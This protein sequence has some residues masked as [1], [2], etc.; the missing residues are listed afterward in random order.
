MAVFLITLPRNC[1]VSFLGPGWSCKLQNTDLG[2]DNAGISPS[3]ISLQTLQI[4]LDGATKTLM[5]MA[6]DFPSPCGQPL[7]NLWVL[8]FQGELLAGPA[9]EMAV[10]LGM[11][12]DGGISHQCSLYAPLWFGLEFQIMKKNPM[13]IKA[14]ALLWSPESEVR[15]FY[16]DDH[17]GIS[18]VISK[19]ALDSMKC[20]GVFKFLILDCG[21]V[22]S[23]LSSY[24]ASDEFHLSVFKEKHFKCF[25]LMAVG[26]IWCL[27]QL[28]NPTIDWKQS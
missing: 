17:P 26:V 27:S 7:L 20:V 13:C 8:R 25:L 22:Q 9:S 18:P 15:A 3:W 21:N 28:F 10:C 2:T 4:H 11:W 19:Q 12:R 16:F 6:T 1:R 24:K 5:K 23:H 14:I